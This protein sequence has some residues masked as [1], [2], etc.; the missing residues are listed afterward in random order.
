MPTRLKDRRRFI[1]SVRDCFHGL[2]YVII[3]E[4]NFKREIVIGI[5][6]LIASAVL[7][8]NKIEFTIIVITIALVL[9]A[10]IVNTAIEQIV[11]LITKDYSKE[12]GQIKDIAASGVLLMSF[13]SVVVGLLIFGSK[14]LSMIGG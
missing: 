3:N 2:E 8:V 4:D 11:D 9:F 7:K 12:A 10:E 13:I 1:E 14:I 5:L 6:A